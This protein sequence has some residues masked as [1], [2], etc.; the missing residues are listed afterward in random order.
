MTGVSADQTVVVALALPTG[1]VAVDKGPITVTIKIR[2][3]TGTRTFSAGLR[4][5][6]ANNTLTYALSTDHV[7]V[8]IGGSTADL[9]RLS[10]AALVMDL[11]VTGLKAGIHDVEVT[12]NPAVGTTV[13]AISPPSVWVTIG[14]T[15]VT[16]PSGGASPLP[17]G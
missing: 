11:D 5:I 15:A 12:A 17:G 4:L 7:L 3:V 16:T 1:I 9:D 8:T 6:G 10:G 13:V 2:P 14:T